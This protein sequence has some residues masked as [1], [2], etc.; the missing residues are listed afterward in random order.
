MTAVHVISTI[1]S[2]VFLLIVALVF[3]NFENMDS[4]IFGIITKI[5]FG[6][7]FIMLVGQLVFIVN[8]VF[9]LIRNETYNI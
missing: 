3:M 9:S 8:F 1:F 5:M 4:D 7:L 6:L 2:F